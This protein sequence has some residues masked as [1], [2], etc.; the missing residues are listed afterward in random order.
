VGAEKKEGKSMLA[1]LARRKK[2]QEDKSILLAEG[3]DT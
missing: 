2:I 1:S 3:K